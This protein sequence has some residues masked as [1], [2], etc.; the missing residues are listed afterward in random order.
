MLR[1]Q[2]LKIALR[3]MQRLC[4]Q[5]HCM[6][7]RCGPCPAETHRHGTRSRTEV[8]PAT[9]RLVRPTGSGLGQRQLQNVQTTSPR[10]SC[11]P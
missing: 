8:S 9:R 10:P 1:S 4:T 5:I 6:A 3:K 2:G 7:K 11:L